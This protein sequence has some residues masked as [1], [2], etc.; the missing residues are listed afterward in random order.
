MIGTALIFGVVGVCLFTSSE[1]ATG[2]DLVGIMLFAY[3]GYY[4][5]R[6]LRGR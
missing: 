3:A 4:V 5:G 1:P 6:V 2:G